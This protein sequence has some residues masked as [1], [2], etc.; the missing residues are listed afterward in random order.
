MSVREIFTR[1]S[2]VGTILVADKLGQ[3]RLVSYIERFGLG[4]K[5]GVTTRSR[6]PGTL[7]FRGG[8]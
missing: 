1:S 5:T 4:S 8:L 2:N 7:N 6:R 3:D